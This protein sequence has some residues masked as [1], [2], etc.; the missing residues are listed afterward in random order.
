[1]TPGNPPHSWEAWIYIQSLPPH[2]A[3]LLML[4][5]EGSGSDHAYYGSDGEA[6][7]G[8]WDGAYVKPRFRKG[9]WLHVA[10][11]FDGTVFNTYLNG[12]L[13]G[14]TPATFNLRGVSLLIA[15]QARQFA[16]WQRFHGAIDEVRVW[17]RALSQNEIK[18]NMS[19][20]LKGNEN[21]LICLWSFDQNTGRDAHDTTS[22][23]N[24]GQLV[25]TPIWL[26]S[27]STRITIKK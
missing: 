14:T 12:E 21:G 9:E 23:G 26:S 16:T 17:N 19:Q 13:A 6:L 18:L 5:D 25:G 10:A 24:T 8:S 27:N 20:P 3:W 2:R 7:L 11:T 15:K 1:L 4:G 22:N